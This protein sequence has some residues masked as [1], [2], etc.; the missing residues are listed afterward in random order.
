MNLKYDISGRP[1]AREIIHAYGFVIGLLVSFWNGTMAILIPKYDVNLLIAA[2]REYQPT[3]FPGVPTLFISSLVSNFSSS[4]WMTELT[5]SGRK[6]ID[7]SS[8]P[9]GSTGP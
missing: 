8:L 3:F 9:W 2:F 5:S 4:C 1:W 6:L 7:D